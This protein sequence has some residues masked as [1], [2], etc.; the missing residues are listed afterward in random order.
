[1]IS[2]RVSVVL[3]IARVRLL[4]CADICSLIVFRNICSVFW[5]RLFRETGELVCAKRRRKLEVLFVYVTLKVIVSFELFELFEIAL[6]YL[7]DVILF[8]TSV[9]NK[10][11]CSLYRNLMSLLFV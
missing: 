5:C 11:E 8:T 3:N 9:M 7:Q 1:M 2:L 4:V 6:C 10:R